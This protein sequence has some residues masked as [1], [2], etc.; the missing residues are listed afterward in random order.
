MSKASWYV[1]MCHFC[2]GLFETQKLND[3]IHNAHSI[4]SYVVLK[5]AITF[6]IEAI[7]DT[8]A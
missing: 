7:D 3:H 1:S 2:G 8:K 5:P 4:S 6:L